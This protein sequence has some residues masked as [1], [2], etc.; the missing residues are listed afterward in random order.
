VP[1]LQLLD[2]LAPNYRDYFGNKASIERALRLLH[3]W[4]KVVYF[5]IP[6]LKDVVCLSVEYLTK[7]TITELFS[8]FK[9]AKMPGSVSGVFAEGDLAALWK[10][11]QTLLEADVVHLTSFLIHLKVAFKMKGVASN[12]SVS[13][14][15]V[16]P[17]LMAPKDAS[18]ID[19]VWPLSAPATVVQT[20]LLVYF[21]VLPRDFAAQLTV[22]IHQQLYSLSSFNSHFLWKNGCLYETEGCL[23]KIDCDELMP[24]CFLRIVD[25]TLKMI[26]KSGSNHVEPSS[27][28]VISIEVCSRENH[29][30]HLQAVI[31][32]LSSLQ[33]SFLGIRR[34]FLSDCCPIHPRQVQSGPC[35]ADVTAPHRVRCIC[36][37]ELIPDV[38]VGEL[39][40]QCGLVDHSGLSVQ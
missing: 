15:I 36:T 28:A 30:T 9:R 25:G 38:F 18:A 35:F 39:L 13:E 21:D 6:E 24:E 33:K 12:G 1:V 7:S 20:R 31:E 11:S 27:Q 2:E 4:G 14:Q 23:V 37:Q 22:Q 40:D 3:E 16:I 29:F 19:D 10:D 17:A 8:P 34:W 26:S 32:S 5:H